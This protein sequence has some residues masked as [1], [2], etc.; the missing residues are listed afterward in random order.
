[1]KGAT[2]Y[3]QILWWCIPDDHNLHIHLHVGLKISQ[4]APCSWVLSYN[5][6]KNIKNLIYN[7]SYI[8]KHW[9]SDRWDCTSVQHGVSVIDITSLLPHLSLPLVLLMTHPVQNI[10]SDTHGM[11]RSSAITC[12]RFILTAKHYI[13]F[14]VMVQSDILSSNEPC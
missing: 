9:S 10:A 14:E 2:E 5:N 12:A 6:I 7:L 1:M 11:W 3:L 13:T 4:T 8:F